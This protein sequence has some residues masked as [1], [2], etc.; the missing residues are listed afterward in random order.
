MAY[1]SEEGY[2]TIGGRV[3]IFGVSRTPQNCIGYRRGSTKETCQKMQS[4][5]LQRKHKVC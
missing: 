2:K 4:M 3:E 1:M 5:M